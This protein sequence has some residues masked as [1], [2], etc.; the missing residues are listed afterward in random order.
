MQD[1]NRYGMH[2]ISNKP[3]RLCNL[4]ALNLGSNPRIDKNGYIKLREAIE[5]SIE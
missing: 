3:L 4:I 5:P 2:N 1:T